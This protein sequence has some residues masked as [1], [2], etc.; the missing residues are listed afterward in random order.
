MRVRW[1]RA[2]ADDLFQIVE[3]VRKENATA[4]QRVA[5][6]VLKSVASLGAFPRRGR[7]GRVD[8]TR[9]LPVLSL[10]FIVVYRLRPDA[11]EIARVIHGA[12]R[13][14]SQE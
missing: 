6:L 14:P 4:A 5:S 7:P 2:A 11:V 9:E 10:P 3:Y 1:S 12:Q 13:W 8:G